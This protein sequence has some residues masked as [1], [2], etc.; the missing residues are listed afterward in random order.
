M[1]VPLCNYTFLLSSCVVSTETGDVRQATS[2]V[3]EHVHWR[4]LGSL[5]IC[6]MGN[7]FYQLR[8]WSCQHTLPWNFSPP[9][10]WRYVSIL[11]LRSIGIAWYIFYLFWK[12]PATKKWWLRFRGEQGWVLNWSTQNVIML[13]AKFELRLKHHGCTSRPSLQLL[14][15]DLLTIQFYDGSIVAQGLR[16]GLGTEAW[17][18]GRP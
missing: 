11:D 1:C 5:W 15:V 17:A 10:P 18:V 8:C 4:N 14:I 12:G 9:M 16:Q 2:S 13:I 3:Y 7:I 6:C